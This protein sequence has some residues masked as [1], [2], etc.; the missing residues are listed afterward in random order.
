M[1]SDKPSSS[2]T[3]RLV[4]FARR[5]YRFG[6]SA[7]K[8]AFAVPL[9]GPNLALFLSAGER[10]GFRSRLARD[11]YTVDG[12][13]P[14]NSSLGDAFNVLLADCADAAPEPCYRRVAPHP[15]GGIVVDLGGPTGTVVV[16]SPHDPAGWRHVSP[17]PVLFSR[18]D[19][20]GSMPDPVAGGSLDEI[21]RLFDLSDRQWA[22]LLGW[23][24]ATFDRDIPHPILAIFGPAGAGKSCLARLLVQLCDPSPCPLRSPP[25]SEK[26]W[27]IAA[28]SS[29]VYAIDNVSDL[30]TWFSETLCK[31]AT[32]DARV[33]RALF[34][35]KGLSVTTL[36]LPVI[37]TSIEPGKLRGDFGD[38]LVMLELTRRDRTKTERDMERLIS[39]RLP[40]WHGA[41]FTALAE[42]LAA[43]ARAKPTTQSARM[44]D[45]MHLVQCA[46]AV[47]VTVDAHAAYRENIRDTARDVGDGDELVAAIT[48]MLQKVP[49]ARWHGTASDLL[50]ALN[51][52]QGDEKPPG[53]PKIANSLSRMLTRAEP[54]LR[55]CGVRYERSRHPT[56]RVHLITLSLL[57]KR[58][59]PLGSLAT[60]PEATFE[61][62][63]D[64]LCLNDPPEPERSP[65]DAVGPPASLP[66]DLRTITERSS[67]APTRRTLQDHQNNPERMKPVESSLDAFS[68][69]RKCGSRDL[70]DE[71][72]HHGRS[73][74]REC[75]KCQAFVCFP[76]WNP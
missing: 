46:D 6:Q 47:G 15:G 52:S 74:R 28:A 34:T 59:S 16:V 38:R 53:W 66:S 54:V 63:I 44:A 42:I 7:E 20:M 69:C 11:F 26:D 27:H 60:E 21:Q 1:S 40:C 37:L 33:V 31:A 18:T 30:K 9:S 32:G 43:R 57:K 25:D 49:D 48:M 3:T 29:W 24:L 5:T 36:K 45:F 4:D 50:Q 72:I 13:V 76:L 8:D 39:S 10:A 2:L 17:S 35:D 23:I 19:V 14:S 41:V 65:N 56:A 58:E 70:I 51:A 67:T 68:T 73:L 71:P 75:A 61:G 12:A 22:L 62:E 55:D 64:D